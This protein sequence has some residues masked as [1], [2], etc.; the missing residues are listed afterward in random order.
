MVGFNNFSKYGYLVVLVTL[1][2]E[3]LLLNQNAIILSKLTSVNVVKS[4][5]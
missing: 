3:K 5:C 2:K 4:I 1:N